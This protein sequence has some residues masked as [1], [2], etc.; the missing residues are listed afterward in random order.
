MG[1]Q[2]TEAW[3]GLDGPETMERSM[4]KFAENTWTTGTIHGSLEKG[5]SLPM[6]NGRGEGWSLL[7]SSC[8]PPPA[9][10]ANRLLHPSASAGWGG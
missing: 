8:P 7:L 5:P 2:W 10:L 6:G 3:E 1:S 4:K 9:T